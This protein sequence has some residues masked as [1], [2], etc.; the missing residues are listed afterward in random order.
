MVPSPPDPYGQLEQA[1]KP[2]QASSGFMKKYPG[3]RI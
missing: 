1:M 3:K 2:L